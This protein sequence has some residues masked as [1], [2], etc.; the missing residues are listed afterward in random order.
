MT[1]KAPTFTQPLQSVVALEGSAATFEAHISGFPV[2]EVSWYRDGQVLSAATLPGVQISFSDGRAKLVISAVTAANSGRYTVQATNGSGQATSTAE[3]LVT[4]ETAPPNFSQ[5]LQ[6]MTAR[7]ASQV[8]LDVR[9]TGI[10]TPVVKFY[11]D[12]VEIQSSPDFQILHEGDLYSLIIAEAYPEDS[13]TYSVNATNSVGRAT[14][15]AEL[16]VQGEDEAVPAKKTK[17]IVST[18]Q[19]TQ[20]TRQARVEKKIEAHFDARSLATAEMVIESATG[21]QLPHKAPPRMPPRPTSHSPTPPAPISAAKAQMARQQSPSPVRQ[22]PSPVRHVRAPTPS[23]V[24]SVSPAGAARLSVS[25]SPIRPVKSPILVRKTQVA[26][27]VGAEVLPPWKQE[28]YVTTSEAMMRDTRVMT[29]TTQ[30]RTEERWEG[31]YGLQEQITISGAA[32]AEAAIGVSAAAAAAAAVSTASAAAAAATEDTD[33]SAAVATV[34]AAVDLAR[35]REPLPSAVEQTAKRTAM[36]AVH[37]QPVQ[38]QIKKEATIV[39][40]STARKAQEQEVISRTREGIATKQ[41]QIHII[42]EKVKKEPVKVPVPKVIIAAGVVKEQEQVSKA[43]EEISTRREEI[44][45]AHHDKMRKEVVKSVKPSVPKVAITT[46]KPKVPTTVIKTSK[47]IAAQQEQQAYLMQEKQ[48]RKEA[49]KTTVVPKVI[50]IEKHREQ[51][52]I[53][54]TREEIAVKREQIHLAHE[55]VAVGKKAGAVA[56]VVH[57]VD[58]ARV[59]EPRE[60]EHAEEAYSEQAAL[61]YGYKEH[62][63]ARRVVELPSEHHVVTKA[64]KKEE[65]HVPPETH[66]AAAEKVAISTQIKR[67]AETSVEK[68]IHVEHTRPRTASPHFTVSKITVPKADHT[69]EVSIAGSAIATL[70]KEL[71][72]TSVPKITKP[73]RPPLAKS[74]EPRMMPEKVVSPQFPFVE[75]AADTYQ[76][77]YD[78]EIKREIGVRMAGG[79]VREQERIELMQEGEPEVIEVARV[80]EPAEVPATPPSIVT[81]LKDKI[82][83]EGESITLECRIS[84]YPPPTVA[85]YREEYRIESSIDFQITFEAGVARLL[86]REAFAEDSGKFTCT[87]TNE[88]GSVS[89]SCHLVV[90]V[91]E[92]FE[93]KEAVSTKVVTEEK[94][95]VESKDVVMAEISA[96]VEDASAEPAAPFFIRK[97]IIQKL[98]E[99]GSII[100]ECQ[101]GGNPKPHV[102]WKK[103][104]L[105]LTTG[106]RYK[107]LHKK[108]TGECRLEISMTFA[109]D[110]GEYTVVARNKHGE[111]SASASLLEEAEYEVYLKSQQETM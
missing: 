36:T 43:R 54:R 45:I 12:G 2:P 10:P 19:I 62:A 38:E 77:R 90:Q 81:A 16:L 47:Q 103:A 89:T 109:D 107:I 82:V 64:V 110:A 84:A 63:L 41:E 13:G 42:Q 91:S 17:T 8:R 39:V 9:V 46:D 97:P 83:M 105:P 26:G 15:T 70:Q 108:E 48:I 65:V 111:V 34:V 37:I 22:S 52:R 11:R 6:S 55:Q 86:I 31:R 44:H 101:V 3:L 73:V 25:T 23:P 29:S 51:D 95:F 58:Q 66:I 76:K 49:E 88:A 20:T 50:A 102:Y 92:E 99:G 32:A 28:G 56:T 68:A 33:R 53:S 85:W 57:A 18:A 7:Q 87:A 35:V 4:A 60:P 67:T 14:S 1:T 78:T 98:I 96:A 71:S 100:F 21:Q 94:R 30:M 69:Y 72:A 61:E 27:A 40:T 79:L 93:S 74:P 59:R 5:R 24:R 104:G 106:Y 80:P 75:T